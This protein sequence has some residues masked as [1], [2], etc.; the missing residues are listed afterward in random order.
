[1]SPEERITLLEQRLAQAE[2]R[3][4]Q[5]ETSNRSY[6]HGMQ[7]QITPP[8]PYMPAPWQSPIWCL[9]NGGAQ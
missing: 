5:L 7:P 8:N 4:A 1:M 3:I 2:M 9:H 6:G